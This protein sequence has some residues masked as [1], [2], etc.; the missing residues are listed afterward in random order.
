MKFLRAHWR[1]LLPFV[2]IWLVI[3]FITFAP[4]SIHG[5]EPSGSRSAGT[6]AQLFDPLP[7]CSR[8]Q[9]SDSA[10]RFVQISHH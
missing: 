2:P 10:P 5:M 4:I 7:F 3:A 6:M 8:Q 9:G 1:H